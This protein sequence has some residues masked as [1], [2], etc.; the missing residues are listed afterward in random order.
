LLLE[1]LHKP[2]YTGI[3]MRFKGINIGK[4]MAN[5]ENLSC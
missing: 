2:A 1:P 4:K 3:F 5:T